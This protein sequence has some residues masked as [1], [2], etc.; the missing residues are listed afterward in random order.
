[1]AI[2]ESMT[3]QLIKDRRLRRYIWCVTKYESDTIKVVSTVFPILYLLGPFLVSLTTTDILLFIIIRQKLTAH[4]DSE[5]KTFVAVLREQIVNYKH[6][7]ISPVMLLL[8]AYHDCSFH[9]EPFA[10]TSYGAT[11]CFLPDTSFLQN[12]TK[13]KFL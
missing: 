8:L 2:H 9:S 7:I 4:R 1:M 13:G 5:R 12:A 6:L 11:T 3:R 10:L